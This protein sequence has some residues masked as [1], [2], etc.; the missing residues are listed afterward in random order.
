MYNLSRPKFRAMD[1]LRHWH[2]GKSFSDRFLDELKCHFGRGMTSQ[3]KSRLSV[4]ADN[5][6]RAAAVTGNIAGLSYLGST[7]IE[8]VMRNVPT[9]AHVATYSQCAIRTHVT[10]SPK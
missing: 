4:M 10:P 7:D 3:A 6:G 2:V 5:P 9:M 1:E 8:V